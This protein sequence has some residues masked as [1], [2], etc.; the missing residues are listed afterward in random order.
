MIVSTLTILIRRCLKSFCVISAFLLYV[1][2]AFLDMHLY[3]NQLTVT[4][5]NWSWAEESIRRFDVLSKGRQSQNSY[6][7]ENVIVSTPPS[8]RHNFD[9]SINFILR[10]TRTNRGTHGHKNYNPRETLFVVARDCGTNASLRT[11]LP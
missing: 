9:P 4:T 1:I 11:R 8:I 10:D 3:I 6:C 7:N 5:A 2:S